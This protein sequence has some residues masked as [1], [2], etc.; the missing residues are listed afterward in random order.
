MMVAKRVRSSDSRPDWLYYSS[1]RGRNA[2]YKPGLEFLEPEILEKLEYDWSDR[3]SPLILH[4]VN[5]RLTG[6]DSRLTV[7]DS[8]LT[9]VD[10]R[11]TVVDSR[12]TVRSIH[13]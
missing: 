2:G 10:S 7:V 11:L 3:F 4:Q 1:S 12:L 6:V 8:R 13:G 5:S 9:V